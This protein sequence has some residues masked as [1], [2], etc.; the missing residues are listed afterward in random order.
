MKP[1]DKALLSESPVIWIQ[2]ASDRV[3]TEDGKRVWF[4][5]DWLKEKT[6]HEKHIRGL[7]AIFMSYL[8]FVGRYVEGN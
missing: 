2:R 3:W 6:P 4:K 5:L 8:V 1:G 7:V